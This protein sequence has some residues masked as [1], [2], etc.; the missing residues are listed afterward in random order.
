MSAQP[1]ISPLHRPPRTRAPFIGREREI[2]DVISLLSRDDVSLLTLTGPGGVGKTRLAQ[3]VADELRAA[4]SD[5][6]IFVPLVS[7]RDPGLVLPAIARAVGLPEAGGIHLSELVQATLIGHD[8]LLLLDNFEQ[9]LARRLP[10]W[11]T[12]CGCS[13]PTILAT[14]RARLQ[15]SREHE[16]PVAPLDVAETSSPGFDDLTGS[17]AVR[18]FV[19][20]SRS[21]KPE[22][23]LTVENGPVIADICRR[24]DGLPLAIELA[25]ARIKVLP[26]ALLRTRSG[27]F[28]PAL[29]RR[30]TRT[31]GAPADHA[32]HH[33][34]ELRF[35][36]PPPEQRFFR[37][38][39][40]FMGGFTLDAFEEV[41]GPLASPALDAI[42]ALTSLVDMSLV[43]AV[44][45]AD[46][47]P[48]YV[49]LET[50]REFAEERLAESDEAT[51]AHLRHVDWCLRFAGDAP[52]PLGE[53]T[54]MPGILRLEAEHAN[55]R[56]GPELAGCVKQLKHPD[57]A[58]D[59]SRIF[60]VSRGPRA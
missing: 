42:D 30:R 10:S 34:V 50:I 41:C 59:P 35:R 15:V 57:E 13:D 6:V 4:F 49:M 38:L 37:H 54:Q 27:A 43:R 21:V 1:P 44:D 33:R 3:R 2:N 55:F 26:P 11:R 52:S 17:E 20:R 7:V 9:V 29:D 28:A 14:S 46:G 22:F 25:A 18:L 23:A 60:L 36:S 47:A 45:A 40:V 32:N 56:R 53:V 5:N 24:V 8:M 31:S 16:Y 12:S 19:M 48:R 58:C 51:A 39:A